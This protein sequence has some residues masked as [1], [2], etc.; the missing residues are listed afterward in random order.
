[1]NR[2]NGLGNSF[3]LV[4]LEKADDIGFSGVGIGIL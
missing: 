3:H 1:M 4:L 2:Q